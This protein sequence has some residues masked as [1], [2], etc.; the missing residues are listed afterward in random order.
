MLLLTYPI[1]PYSLV[2]PTIFAYNKQLLI[3]CVDSLYLLLHFVHIILELLDTAVHFVN[4]TVAFLRADTQET[5]VVLI[6]VNLLFE[7]F[8]AAHQTTTLVIKSVNTTVSYLFQVV[9]EIIYTLARC[10]YVK[11]FVQ[12]I[13]YLMILLIQLILLLVRYM[14]YL[15]IFLGE[16]LNL[17]LDAFFGLIK[18][19]L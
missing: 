18:Q 5:E 10:R 2:F 7:L 8:E 19:F 13:E 16:L 1:F 17:L 14:S 9:T 15:I 11:V 6:G 12:L 3:L 4:E